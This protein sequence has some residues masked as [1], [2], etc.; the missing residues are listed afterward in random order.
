[1]K[2]L[3]K[4][5]VNSG[6]LVIAK[7]LKTISG[8]KVLDVATESGDFIN[9]LMNALKDYNS[10]L[11]IDIA[12]E[13]LESA[14]Q[15]IT[16]E[17][18]EFIEM[19]GENLRFENESFDTVSIA[20]SFHHLKNVK[21]V[22][23]EI[24]RVLKTGGHLIIQEPHCDGEQTEAQKADILQHHWGA[25][26]DNI[27]GIPHN[28]TLTKQE[29]KDIFNNI[30]FGEEEIFESTHFVKCLFCDDKF[31]CEDPKN[32]DIVKFSIKEVKSD[33][34]RLETIENHPDV[35]K[36]RKEGERIIELIQEFGASSASHLFYIGK[37]SS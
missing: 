37:K 13:D 30:G 5:L 8:G 23:N 28:K 27:Q 24:K 6:A 10:F 26:I 15:K 36:L 14:R 9:T 7:K 20:H 25:L 22:L 2:T 34:K 3:P 29:I 35:S 11:G 16:D 1:M 18:V 12:L 21:K 19:N 17:K 32:E 4:G 33:L 31:E